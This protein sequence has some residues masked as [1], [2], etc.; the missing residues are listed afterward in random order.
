MLFLT[1]SLV[2]QDVAGWSQTLEGSGVNS[3]GDQRVSE[4]TNIIINTKTV[5]LCR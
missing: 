1:A 5:I 4:Q 2:G 3:V